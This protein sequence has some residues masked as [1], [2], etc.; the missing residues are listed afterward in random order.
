[1]ACVFRQ[2]IGTH[3]W[4]FELLVLAVAKQF[5]LMWAW[6]P[7]SIYTVHWKFMQLAPPCARLGSYRDVHK[8]MVTPTSSRESHA[9]VR[10]ERH[11]VATLGQPRG[12]SGFV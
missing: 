12:L 11:I 1:M 7:V 4:L 3:V 5:T 10:R 8:H 2:T 6:L 9:A